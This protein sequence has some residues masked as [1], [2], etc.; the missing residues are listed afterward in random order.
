MCPGAIVTGH[1]YDYNHLCGE[2]SQFGTYVQMHEKT[3]N[4]MRERT[5]S[6]ITL[7]PSGN[8]QGSFYYFSLQTGRRLHRRRCTPLPMPDEVL[9]QVHAMANIQKSPTGLTFQRMDDSIHDD[10]EDMEALPPDPTIMPTENNDNDID[11]V[12]DNSATSTNTVKLTDNNN[13]PFH[14]NTEIEE[15]MII[16]PTENTGVTENSNPTNATVEQNHDIIEN[17]GVAT[18]NNTENAGVPGRNNI[19][20][21]STTTSARQEPDEDTNNHQMN[22]EIDPSNILPDNLCRRQKPPT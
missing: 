13:N 8:I 5:V 3:N 9:E 19:T 11:G 6:A 2:G 16:V 17:A 21:E 22:S 18:N 14:D 10:P 4:T 7:R 1:T 20:N 15:E 12:D